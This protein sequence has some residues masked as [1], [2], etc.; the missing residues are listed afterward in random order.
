MKRQS[1]R[2]SLCGDGQSSAGEVSLQR[3]RS[4]GVPRRSALALPGGAVLNGLLML[5]AGCGVMHPP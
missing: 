1:A 3:R 2:A 5:L 4:G